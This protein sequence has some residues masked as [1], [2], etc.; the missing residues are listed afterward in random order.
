[1]SM[2]IA[3]DLQCNR[4]GGGGLIGLSTTFWW[5]EGL[6]GIYRLLIIRGNQRRYLNTA[7]H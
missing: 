1:M 5:A 2:P 3:L 4:G 6:S 7:A